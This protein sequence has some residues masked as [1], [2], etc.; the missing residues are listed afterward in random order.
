MKTYWRTIQASASLLCAI[1]GCLF[2][3][4]L[5]A[6]AAQHVI[7]RYGILSDSI[8]V[9]DLKKLE[10]TGK[11]DGNYKKYTQKLP[12]GKRLAFFKI[13]QTKYP[14]N[15]AN[16]SRFLETPASSA[17]LENLAKV[18][19]HADSGDMQALRSAL[20]KGASDKLS[21]ISFIEAYPRAELE[22]DLKKAS[23]TFQQ[24]HLAYKQTEQFINA[25][26]PRLPVIKN[27]QFDAKIDPTQPGK[28]TV[29]VIKLN[30]KDEK[31]LSRSVPVDIYFPKTPSSQKKSVKSVVVLS[32]GYSSNKS[33]MVYIARHLASHGY[34][35]AAVEH[36]GS[37][38]NYQF[39]L[40]KK[41]GVAQ[42][43]QPQEFIERPRD[44]SFVLDK[45]TE[46][47]QQPNHQLF[48]QVSS[49]ST[50]VIGHSFGGAT[51][52]AIAGAT[53]DVDYLKS[54]CPQ[55]PDHLNL[56][57]WLQCQA[58]NLPEKSYQLRDNRVKQV[59]SLNPVTSLMFGE[60]GLQ[61]IQI[62][63]LMLASSADKTTPALSEQVISFDKIQS[64]KWL[65]G[66]VG[67]THGSAKDPASTAD[68]EG[69][70]INEVVGEKATTI[71]KYI[72]GIS[73]AFI[74]RNNSPS[75]Q[76]FLTNEYAQYSSSQKLPIYLVREIP[77][78]VM[79]L[80]YQSVEQRK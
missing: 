57:E 9:S 12:V 33:D 5:P 78:D 4:N 59:I 63:V 3:A 68:R 20:V 8:S 18:T 51:A 17:V 32:H 40:L 54:H 7:F 47:N 24:L 45:L 50:T 52:L 77:K 1:A 29:D 25:V 37:N 44:I 41:K 19:I 39:D 42:F 30:L 46:F 70:K 79:E 58:T 26:T 53:I 38:Q 34:I 76:T 6:N 27:P 16:L 15:A 28:A 56:P 61:N 75:Y 55:R 43:I 35:V 2:S 36:V 64:P 73:L 13:L 80:V 49:D 71:R 60:T 74:A 10:E 23:A 21:I 14:V 11:L 66:I 67:A 69:K 31:R 72:Q 65:V 48:G 62:P 22:I